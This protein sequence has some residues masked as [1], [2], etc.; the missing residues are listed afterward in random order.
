MDHI[1]HSRGGTGTVQ[2][3]AS[4]G[5]GLILTCCGCW[6]SFSVM[7]CVPRFVMMLLFCLR[8]HRS[9]PAAP[10]PGRRHRRRRRGCCCCSIRCQYSSNA[11]PAVAAVACH[12]KGRLNLL[13]IHAAARRDDCRWTPSQ[14]RIR[15]SASKRLHLND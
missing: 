12:N 13:N 9:V 6:Q 11:V 7:Q 1:S 3:L 8:R 4:V 14:T 10:V 15:R 2:M 5:H